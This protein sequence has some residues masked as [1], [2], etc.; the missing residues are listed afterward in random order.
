[1]VVRTGEFEWDEAKALSNARKHG[2]TFEEA[3]EVFADPMA[4]VYADGA[5]AERSLI[6]GYS[7]SRLL[8]VVT[9]N[10]KP[11]V[12]FASSAHAAR[13]RRNGGPMAKNR[14]HEEPSKASLR[15]IPEIDFATARFLGR[16]LHAKRMRQRMRYMPIERE[17]FDRLG[18][19]AG[20]LAI[21]RAIA[22]AAPGS[23]PGKKRR[24]AA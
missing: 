7:F 20:I 5:H 16:G 14:K 10:W 6:V 12:H 3:T 23:R 9:S 13:P 2:V 11:M 19:T 17:L 4:Q 18:G 15:E 22:N 21:L 8:T 24:T 1:M